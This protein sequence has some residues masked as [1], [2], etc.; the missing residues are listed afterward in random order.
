MGLRFQVTPL[1]FHGLRHHGA[2]PINILLDTPAT[3]RMHGT[4]RDVVLRM[5]APVLADLFISLSLCLPLVLSLALCLFARVAHAHS[6]LTGHGH[7]SRSLRCLELPS[8]P[9]GTL[10]EGSW[11][12]QY[13]PVDALYEAETI[14]CLAS[15]RQV[16]VDPVTRAACDFDGPPA[17]PVEG[18]C[19]QR[20]CTRDRCS[21]S[22]EDCERT[23][24][25][26]WAEECDRCDRPDRLLERQL[27][28]GR[29]W[30]GMRPS[31]QAAGQ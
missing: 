4:S 16:F 18:Y 23:V 11:G 10:L 13:A 20:R 7:S 9:Q 8:W 15:R 1:G 30:V 14:D 5:H 2:Y 31:G 27:V 19:E 3:Y 6:R 21:G 29:S 24:G 26:L 17:R 22:D 12:R 28:E 25:W